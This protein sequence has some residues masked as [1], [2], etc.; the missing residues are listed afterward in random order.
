MT[1]KKRNGT[2]ISSIVFIRKAIALLFPTPDNNTIIR[3]RS[4]YTTYHRKDEKDSYRSV[5]SIRHLIICLRDEWPFHRYFF[6]IVLCLFASNNPKVSNIRDNRF[7]L[8][9][10]HKVT[11]LQS[12]WQSSFNIF[13]A[14]WKVPDQFF[15]KNR[16]SKIAHT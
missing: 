5:S 4:N 7:W 6:L 8:I 9:I 2:I 11:N 14:L 15:W 10:S 16:K 3:P 12:R 13:T 1:I